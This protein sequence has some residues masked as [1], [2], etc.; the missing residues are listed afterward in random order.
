MLCKIIVLFTFCL[1]VLQD[2]L[3]E[4]MS[5]TQHAY[6]WVRTVARMCDMFATGLFCMQQW[7]FYW[8]L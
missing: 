1:Q 2:I 4:H 6:T 5:M 8:W 3:L 7:Q